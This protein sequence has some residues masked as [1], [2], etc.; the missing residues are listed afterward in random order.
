MTSSTFTV[1][2]QIFG[3][4]NIFVLTVPYLAIDPQFPHHLNSFDNVPINYNSTL[5]KKYFYKI[6]KSFIISML[7]IK[8]IDNNQLNMVNV[9]Q[10]LTVSRRNFTGFKESYM[11]FIK[12]N[13]R[14]V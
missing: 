10:P 13:A 9:K 1:S 4:T 11:N 6:H 12:S 3:F 14:V 2:M 7:Y 5:V 8:N